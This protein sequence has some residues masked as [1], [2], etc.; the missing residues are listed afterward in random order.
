MS[1]GTELSAVVFGQHVLPILILV[2]FSSGVVSRTKFAT[3]T[4]LTEEELKENIRR[5][6]AN[7]PAE[8]LQ[9]VSLNLFHQCE[10]CVYVEGQHFQHHL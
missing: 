4:P 7:I 6:I 9:G 8:Q 5:E 1:L 3:V 10:E 2:M